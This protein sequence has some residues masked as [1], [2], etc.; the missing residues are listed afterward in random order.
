VK[1]T[2]HLYL[3]PRSRKCGYS[4]TSTPQYTLGKTLLFYRESRPHTYRSVQRRDTKVQ[5][6]T[7]RDTYSH[8]LTHTRICRCKHSTQGESFT[9]PTVRPNTKCLAIQT[10]VYIS[11]CPAG[12]QF[13]NDS[14]RY[15]ALVRRPWHPTE[16][17]N[18][19]NSRPAYTSSE[20]KVQ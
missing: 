9:R 3:V 1:L 16:N 2:T 10:D 14:R 20:R 4:Y 15:D 19:W 11:R 12:F 6:N 17:Q 7:Q 5:T 13:S 8:T 18:R